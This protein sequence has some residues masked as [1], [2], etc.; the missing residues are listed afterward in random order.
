MS[1]RR[2]WL[3]ER[4]A[5]CLARCCLFVLAHSR[6][7]PRERQ[8]A[9]AYWEHV[10]HLLDP[11]DTGAKGHL[12]PFGLDQ[13]TFQELWARTR[14]EFG[15]VLPR[16]SAADGRRWTGPLCNIEIVRSQAGLRQ[17][18]LSHVRAIFDESRGKRGL[19]KSASVEEVF[20]WIA[21]RKERLKPYAQRVLARNPEVARRQVFGEWQRRQLTSNKPKFANN[22]TSR[23][24]RER[25]GQRIESSRLYLQLEF[26]R[27]RLIAYRGDAPLGAKQLAAEMRR[28]RN[29]AWTF[30]ELYERFHVVRSAAPGERV[31]LFIDEQRL[32]AEL[33]ALTELSDTLQCWRPAELEGLPEGWALVHYREIRRPRPT[34][35]FSWALAALELRGGLPV[36]RG[37]WLLGAGPVVIAEG[38]AELEMDGEPWPVGDGRADLS[39]LAPGVHEVHCG[40]RV[41][42]LEMVPG[43]RV[44][45]VGNSSRWVWPDGSGWPTLTDCDAAAQRSLDG[46][47]FVDVTTQ[48]NTSLARDAGT[49]DFAFACRRRPTVEDV[50]RAHTEHKG[51]I[52]ALAAVARGRA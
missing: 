12:G 50:G 25:L 13:P 34:N 52:L 22:Q 36:D 43:R 30:D 18:D 2:G 24:F 31:L 6:V 46:P 14:D 35:A 40:G 42:R 32:P 26:S 41:E 16:P 45:E 10:R 21:E 15:I 33:A 11:S 48:L 3:P 17:L 28:L 47:L 5:D 38:A 39:T 7:A 23:A 4:A 51:E 1:K 37:R 20:A 27:R 8:G 44:L 19:A 29:H 9:P 49:L